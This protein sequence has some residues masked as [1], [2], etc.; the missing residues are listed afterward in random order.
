MLIALVIRSLG[1]PSALWI[2]LFCLAIALKTAFL[3]IT[4]RGRQFKWSLWMKLIIAGVIM[5]FASMLFK[6]VFPVPVVRN[7]LFYG[8]ITLKTIALILLFTEKIKLSKNNKG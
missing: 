2:P 5:I 7:I 8:A 4:L 3:V 6:Y 1:A